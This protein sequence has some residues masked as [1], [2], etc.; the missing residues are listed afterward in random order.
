MSRRANP[1]QADFHATRPGA[2][3]EHSELRGVFSV[4][5]TISGKLERPFKSAHCALI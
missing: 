4:K 1:G 5:A 2:P 3:P